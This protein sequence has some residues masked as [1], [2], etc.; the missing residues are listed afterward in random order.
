MDTARVN[1]FLHGTGGKKPAKQGSQPWWDEED[2][3]EQIGE[4]PGIGQLI[5]IYSRCSKCCMDLSD[6]KSYNSKVNFSYILVT[7]RSVRCSKV[8]YM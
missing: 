2:D 8:M 6:N 5:V 3:S 7:F 4:D 1:K